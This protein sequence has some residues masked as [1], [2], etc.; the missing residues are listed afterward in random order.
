MGLGGWDRRRIDQVIASQRTTRVDLAQPM[1]ILILY[2]TAEVLED[3]DVSFRGDVYGRDAPVLKAL[4]DKLPIT[5]QRLPPIAEPPAEAPSDGGWVVQVASLTE[6]AGARRLLQELTAQG[7]SAF[8][9][10]TVLASL[11]PSLPELKRVRTPSLLNRARSE[12]KL[13]LSKPVQ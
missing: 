12:L 13:G 11:M 1:P 4:D 10:L 8:I 7:F 9:E 6:A 5:P 3:A 2:W